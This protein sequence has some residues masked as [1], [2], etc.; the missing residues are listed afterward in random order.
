MPHP[1]KSRIYRTCD[2]FPF[3]GWR[4]FSDR[5]RLQRA[6]V[7]RFRRKIK[8]LHEDWAHGNIDW[9]EVQ[10]SVAA[11]IGHAMHGDTWRLREQIFEQPFPIKKFPSA[12]PRSKRAW[13]EEEE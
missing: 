6:N 5:A 10:A 13:P 9:D 4:I 12:A 7:V 8:A 3:L 2:G 11:W 1:G